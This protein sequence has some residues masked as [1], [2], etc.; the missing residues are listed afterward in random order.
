MPVRPSVVVFICVTLGPVFL[1]R[2][3]FW[4]WTTVALL[5]A[6]GVTFSFVAR[7]HKQSSDP[8]RSPTEQQARHLKSDTLGY[9][10]AMLAGLG[11]F[12][13]V[14]TFFVWLGNRIF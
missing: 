1:L 8:K 5:A 10:G 9:F 11:G 6:C 7:W 3:R 2:T 13:G 14:I 12:A 4:V